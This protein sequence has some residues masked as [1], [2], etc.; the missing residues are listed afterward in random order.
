MSEGDRSSGWDKRAVNRI[1]KEQYGGLVEMFAEHGWSTD[2]RVISQIAPTKVVETYSSIKAF[3]LAHRNGL[4]GNWVLNPLAGLEATEPKVLLSGAFGFDPYHWP[5]LPFTNQGRVKTIREQSCPGFFALVYATKTPQVEASIRGRVLGLMQLSHVTSPT[6]DLLS[7]QGRARKQAL[8]S[9]ANTWNTAFR[10]M[11]AWEIARDHRP[12]VAELAQETYSATAGKALAHYG[13][14]LKPAEVAKILE[15]PLIP[16]PLFG[17][18]EGVEAVLAEAREV[19]KPSRPG[20]VSQN[21][22]MVREAEGPKYV[23]I[24]ELQGNADHFLGK[25]AE[26]RSILKVGFSKSP[27]TR[28]LAFNSALPKGAFH[29]RVLRSSLDEG[30][31]PFP[32]SHKAKEVEQAMI[33]FLDERGGSL[34]RE[35]FLSDKVGIQRAWNIRKRYMGSSQS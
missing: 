5:C 35:F 24:L 9:K 27:A 22:Y 33:T 23:Y 25:A 21:P 31:P 12:C 32:S 1:A 29:W 19:L 17:I 30:E 11:R 28:C 20:P 26:G 13:A 4:K 8:Q 34:G 15:L 18:D 2:G 14:W 6:E 3:E 16:Q 7:P 10:A